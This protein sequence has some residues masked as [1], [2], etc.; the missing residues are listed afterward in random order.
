MIQK[1]LLYKAM[2]RFPS[3]KLCYEKVAHNKVS[4]DIYLTIPFGKKFFAWFTY[5][6]KQCICIFLQIASKITKEIEDINV[7]PV[8]FDDSL[9]IGT[10]LYGTMFTHS[11]QKFFNVEDIHYYKGKHTSMQLMSNKL[12]I[13][14]SLFKNDL[15][16]V[17]Y[18][19]NYVVFGM[20]N[21]STNYEDLV[22]RGHFL[23]YNLYSIQGRLMNRISHYMNVRYNNRISVN[24][25][26]LPSTKQATFLIRPNL[27]N[28]IYELYYK[29]SK[30]LVFHSI[31]LINNYKISVEMNKLYRN[32]REN[33]NLDTLEESEDEDEFENIDIDKY[34]DMSK[35]Y[36]IKCTYYPN[37][38]KWAPN[39]AE[40]VKDYSL[41]STK[42]EIVQIE[43]HM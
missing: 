35:E 17:S 37:F 22:K 6:E 36:L 21:M 16:Q 9:S 27:Q 38:Q 18:S 3:F 40:I 2:A 39:P 5:I 8:C 25:K 23:N 41:I 31:A 15:K 26:A 11:K 42:K 19:P 29:E 20:P 12:K 7:F 24:Y 10:V 28:D 33:D 14:N 32:I 13:Y 4:S 43:Q 30:E 34:V 1:Q